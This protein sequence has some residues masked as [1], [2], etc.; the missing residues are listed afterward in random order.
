MR[1]RRINAP[2]RAVRRVGPADTAAT[3]LPTRLPARR[4]W[5]LLAVVVM[6]ALSA[7]L[8]VYRPWSGV[9]ADDGDLDSE[10]L[11]VDG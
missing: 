7:L 3:P 2:P 1:S 9:P 4:L 8:S 6:L 5:T 10:E 11:S